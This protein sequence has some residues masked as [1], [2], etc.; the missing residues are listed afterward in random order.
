MRKPASSL[1]ILPDDK[2][3]VNVLISFDSPVLSN[4]FAT[5]NDLSEFPTELAAS[6]TFVFVRESGDVAQPQLDQGWRFRQCDRYLRPKDTAR[7]FGQIGRYAE[8]PSQNVQELGYINNKPLVFDNEP[9]RHK[10]DRR[11]RRYRLDR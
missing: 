5:L 8:H 9:A 7:I 10:I 11:D 2:F 3:S 1:I 6:R 4:Q